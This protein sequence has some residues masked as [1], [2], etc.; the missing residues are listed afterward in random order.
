[1]LHV[2]HVAGWVWHLMVGVALM[3]HKVLVVAVMDWQWRGQT[4]IVGLHRPPW[5]WVKRV[6][7]QCTHEISQWLARSCSGSQ[8]KLHLVH[9]CQLL[10][11]LLLELVGSKTMHCSGRGEEVRH[12]FVCL[13]SLVS[14][15][16]TRWTRRTVCVCVSVCVCV[17]VRTCMHVCVYIATNRPC[18][19]LATL[20]TDAACHM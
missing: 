14:K 19:S 7:T 17:C 3:V 8:Q 16:C 15:I 13:H 20:A 4:C 1:M 9:T 11:L 18:S 6:V 2:R 5:M 10:L 12:G